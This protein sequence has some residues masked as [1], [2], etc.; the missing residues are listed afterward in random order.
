L[1]GALPENRHIRG[2]AGAGG[3][4]LEDV[5]APGATLRGGEG[6]R[7]ARRRGFRV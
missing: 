7:L 6:A 2:N 5:T 3:K 4:H 1:I